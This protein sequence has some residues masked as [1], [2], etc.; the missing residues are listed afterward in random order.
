MYI[1]STKDS[2]FD[3]NKMIEKKE[4]YYPATLIL[5]TIINIHRPLL[6]IYI[7]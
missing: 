7:V 4:I 6:L 2:S 3:L 5:S 1:L